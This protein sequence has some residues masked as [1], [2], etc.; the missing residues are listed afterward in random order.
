MKQTIVAVFE[1]GTQAHVA[2]ERLVNSGF[3]RGLI[4]FSQNY[5]HE[6]PECLG[7]Q[8]HDDEF[9]AERIAVFFNSIMDEENDRT[10]FIEVARGGGAIVT[11]MVESEK[12][13]DQAAYILDD[14]GAMDSDEMKN[15]PT[16]P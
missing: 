16:I 5:R 11:V 12:D 10:K 9:F 6:G 2:V 8:S 13:A 7:G 15:D 3:N 1:N 14:S 4:D